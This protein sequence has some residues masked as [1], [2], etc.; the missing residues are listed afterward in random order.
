MKSEGSGVTPRN[1]VFRRIGRHIIN[2]QRVEMQLKL[3]VIAGGTS[4]TP[5]SEEGNFTKKKH[6]RT[7]PNTSICQ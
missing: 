1:E 4:G 6:S 5:E 2:F 3:L 7:T